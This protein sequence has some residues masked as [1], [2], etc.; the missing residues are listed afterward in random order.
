MKYTVRTPDPEM[1]YEAQDRV[2]FLLFIF[3]LAGPVALI[4]KGLIWAV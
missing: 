2:S 3:C 1:S 4:I